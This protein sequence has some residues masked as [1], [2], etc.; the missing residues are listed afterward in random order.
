MI[1]NVVPKVAVKNSPLTESPQTGAAAIMDDTV[2]TMD[3][4]RVLMGGEVTVYPNIRA[5][6]KTPVIRTNIRI[7][8]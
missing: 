1:K 4:S 7:R 3:D 2:Y 6:A 5:A 8:R